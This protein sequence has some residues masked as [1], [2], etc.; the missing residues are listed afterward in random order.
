MK[1]YDMMTIDNKIKQASGFWKDGKTLDAG[2]I[3]FEMVLPDDRPR[4][5][6]RILKCALDRSALE[7]VRVQDVLD[8]AECPEEWDRA[9]QIFD[10]LRDV[11]LELD[12]KRQ[13][14]LTKKEELLAWLFSIA[15]L[16]AKVTYN[17]T[18]PPDE[19]D[20]DSGWW[21]A[22]TLRGFVDCL[23]DESFAEKAWLILSTLDDT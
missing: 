4:W 12:E 23:G 14:G 20:E 3:V 21:I 7:C 17:A 9:H 1:D 10:V 18:N 11:T 19:F 13:K 6:S 5:A 22:V 2:R 16:V 8:I 15:E